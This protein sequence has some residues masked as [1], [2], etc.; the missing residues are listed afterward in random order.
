MI[1]T[2]GAFT[3]GMVGGVGRIAPPVG[4]QRWPS[5]AYRPLAVAF[6]GLDPPEPLTVSKAGE[7]GQDDEDEEEW[8]ALRVGYVAQADEDHDGD[9]ACGDGA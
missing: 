3:D 5:A 2:V 6:G 1:T 9:E 7:H 8:N 4:P